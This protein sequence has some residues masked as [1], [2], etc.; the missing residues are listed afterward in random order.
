MI[1]EAVSSGEPFRLRASDILELNRLA[2]QDLEP[3]AGTYRTVPVDIG[4]SRHEPPRWERVPREVENLCDYV[5][6]HAGQSPIHLASYVMWRLN[7]IHPFCDGNGRTTRATSY[8]VLCARL[9][10]EIPGT[11]AVPD[12]ISGHKQPYYDALEK[13]DE[14]DLNGQVNVT[15]MEQILENAL[16]AQLNSVVD[17]ARSAHRGARVPVTPVGIR[18][19]SHTPISPRQTGWRGQPRWLRWLQVVGSGLVL[20]IGAGWALLTNWDNPRVVQVREMLFSSEPAPS[21]STAPPANEEP[22]AKP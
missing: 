20:L 6:G 16:A 10:Y 8:L 14:A 4:G 13:A 3:T 12:V 11:K 2:V 5:N 15:A 1:R 21:T 18:P 9:G 22:A 19:E 17:A 7:W